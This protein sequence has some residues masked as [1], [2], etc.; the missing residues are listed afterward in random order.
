MFSDVNVTNDLIQTH[1]SPFESN[2]YNR[3][4]QEQHQANCAQ[5]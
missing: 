4:E 3:R 1:L 2:N 5:Q